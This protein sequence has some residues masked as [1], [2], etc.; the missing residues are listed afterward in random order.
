MATMFLDFLNHHNVT[1][2]VVSTYTVRI[3]LW[4][5]F[6]CL[7]SY[8]KP[9]KSAIANVSLSF[10]LILF[11]ILDCVRYLW[12]YDSYARTYPLE[13]TFIATL[14]TPHILVALWAG[15]TLTKHTLTRFGYQ[16]HGPGCKEALSDKANGVR[17]CLSRR[18]S[19]YQELQEQCDTTGR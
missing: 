14:L 18:N 2:D 19:G 1:M 12:W 11:G 5:M 13:L 10:H 17:R 16:F 15:Y 4:M 7:V 9:C 6:V 3:L 8:V